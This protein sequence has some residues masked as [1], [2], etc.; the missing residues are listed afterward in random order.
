M[1]I[2]KA[3]GAFEMAKNQQ[4]YQMLKNIREAL[5]GVNEADAGIQK[6]KKSL[7]AIPSDSDLVH[8]NQWRFHFPELQK[9]IENREKKFKNIY[10]EESDRKRIGVTV[11]MLLALIL[12]VSVLIVVSI[13]FP[14]QKYYDI[15]AEKAIFDEYINPNITF[16]GAFVAIAILTI[17]AIGYFCDVLVDFGGPILQVSKWIVAVVMAVVG[18]ILLCISI[19]N[20]WRSQEGSLQFLSFLIANVACIL[21]WLVAI[22]FWIPFMIVVCGMMLGIYAI[23]EYIFD[24]FS[25]FKPKEYCVYQDREFMNSIEYKRLVKQEEA[26]QEEKREEYRI[27]YNQMLQE[28]QKQREYYRKTIEKLQTIKENCLAEINSSILHPS[29]RKLEIVNKILFYFDRNRAYN[30]KDA[31]NEMAHD[32]Q[33]AAY[34]SQIK[35]LKREIDGLKGTIETMKIEQFNRLEE[36][37]QQYQQEL[38][39]QKSEYSDQISI[40]I[41]N[42]ESYSAESDKNAQRLLE[43]VQNAE[44]KRSLDSRQ[45]LENFQS[46]NNSIDQ[47]R[48]H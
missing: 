42:M 16:F 43:A 3:K 10:S 25:L 19:G 40:L 44:F 38:N 45:A 24:S 6:A 8:P 11:L 20:M 7:Q 18:V 30:L 5:I 27:H 13:R 29:Q 9:L 26:M 33:L 15:Y 4:E 22:V 12:I 46:I 41:K 2:Y 32:E 36:L 47:M 14:M 17:L 23:E 48:Y 37:Q 28:Y 35:R 1:I 34:V 39:R 21:R 31:L